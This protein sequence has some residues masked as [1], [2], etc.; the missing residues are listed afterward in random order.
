MKLTIKKGDNVKV[1]AGDSKGQ[2]GR[3]LRIDLKK[4]RAT[5]EGVNMMKR[6]TKPSAQNPDGG[7]VEKEGTI[8]LSNLMFI[9]AAGNATRLGRR[10]SKE[11]KSVRYSKKSGE[12]V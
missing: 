7:I 1:L 4:M 12:D 8:H 10:E 9:D 3:I 11:G 5:V 2:S 6:H